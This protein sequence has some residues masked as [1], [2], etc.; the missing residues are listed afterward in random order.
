MH[1]EHGADSHLT[2]LLFS[3]GGGTSRHEVETVISGANV[4]CNLSG[5][6]LAD[7]GQFMDN[8]I[9]MEHTK[10]HCTS[11]QYYKGTLSGKGEGAFCGRILVQQDAQKTDA[12][13]THQALLLSDSAAVYSKPQLEIYADDVKCSHGATTGNLDPNALFYL[14]SRG[15]RKQEA[16]RMLVVAFAK[17]V[18][19]RVP[20]E[21]LQ[22][23]LGELLEARLAAMSGAA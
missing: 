12:Y 9:C 11:D 8:R 14:R 3:L 13:Q 7:T 4:A 2:S 23:Q 10:P 5:L 16:E 1:V 6:Y 20:F 19:E 17:E 22:A 18:V 21:G 15:I